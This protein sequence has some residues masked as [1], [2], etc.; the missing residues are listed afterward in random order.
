MKKSPM[1]QISQGCDRKSLGR[2]QGCDRM[3]DRWYDRMV[4][5]GVTSPL[6]ARVCARARE[7]AGT[8]IYHTVPG[9]DIKRSHYWSN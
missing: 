7:G 3:R 6:G 4:V 8:H 5:S 9:V 2:D 1:V